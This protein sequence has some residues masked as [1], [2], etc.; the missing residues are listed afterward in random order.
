MKKELNKKSVKEEIDFNRIAIDK[1]DEKILHLIHRRLIYARKIGSLKGR[2]GSKI[3]RPDREKSIL[4]KLLQQNSNYQENL[5]QKS[6]L[7]IFKE[8]ISACRAEESYLAIGYLGPEGTFTHLAAKKQFGSAANYFSCKSIKEVFSLVENKQIDYGIVPIENTTEGSVS[9]TLDLL[10]DTS[11]VIY[12]ELY[13]AINHH[14]IGEVKN[15]NQIKRI[16]AHP[17]TF[18]QCREFIA[19]H[20]PNVRQ[21]PMSSNAEAVKKIKKK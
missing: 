17:Q 2:E 13:L 9:E 20:I 6:V 1:I 18:G 12:G 8:V 11:L 4:D 5:N 10:I 15:F 16:Y 3:Y 19:N 7:N 21:I 14:L